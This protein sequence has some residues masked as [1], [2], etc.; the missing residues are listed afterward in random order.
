MTG[1]SYDAVRLLSASGWSADRTLDIIDIGNQYYESEIHPNDC[2]LQFLSHFWNLVIKY[3]L[4]S[5]PKIPA[6]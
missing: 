2:G 6:A 1:L 5:S 4:P 3:L